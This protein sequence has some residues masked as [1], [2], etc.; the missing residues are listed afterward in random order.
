VAGGSSAG[1]SDPRWREGNLFVDGR[2]VCDDMFGP[3]DALVACRSSLSRVT[4]LHRT[5]GFES[6][7]AT[8]LSHFG[9]VPSDFGMDNVACEGEEL[10]IRDCPHIGLGEENCG[11]HEGAGVICF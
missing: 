10:D 11:S 1:G 8:V 7:Q 6:G 2:P 4:T 9:L 3:E 5:L